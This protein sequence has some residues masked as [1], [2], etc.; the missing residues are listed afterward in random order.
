MAA[1]GEAAAGS[2]PRPAITWTIT[3]SSP[4]PANESTPSPS[5]LSP[6]LGRAGRASARRLQRAQARAANRSPSPTSGRAGAAEG[7]EQSPWCPDP[8]VASASLLA[9]T[10]RDDGSKAG[11]KQVYV[12]SNVCGT[13]HRSASPQLSAPQRALQ[14]AL[15]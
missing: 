9:P 10:L 11:S 8:F 14:Q 15:Q 2:P 12:G 5:S 1:T 4:P 3:D 7:D 6:N 13:A